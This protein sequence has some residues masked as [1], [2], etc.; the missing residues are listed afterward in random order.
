MIS[1]AKE[2]FFKKQSVRFLDFSSGMSQRRLVGQMRYN[3]ALDKKQRLVMHD[4]VTHALDESGTNGDSLIDALNKLF[5]RLQ[6]EGV[7]AGIIVE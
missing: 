3:D 7:A 1:T 6:E 2:G 4:L 5:K